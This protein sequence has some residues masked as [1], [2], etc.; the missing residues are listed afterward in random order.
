[1]L[2]CIPLSVRIDSVMT[3]TLARARACCLSISGRAAVLPLGRFFDSLAMLA[4]RTSSVC[5]AN[6][7]SNAAG[8]SL[9]LGHHRH[10]QRRNSAKGCMRSFAHD[11]DSTRQHD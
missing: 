11:G 10:S 7:Q 9:K 4:S 8:A 1:M 3:T 6:C 5:S 2:S